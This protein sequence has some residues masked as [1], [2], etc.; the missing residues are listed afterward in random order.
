MKGPIFILVDR[1][2]AETAYEDV[3]I[4]HGTEDYQLRQIMKGPYLSWQTG[5]ELRQ[6]MKGPIFIMVDRTV[7]ELAYEGANIYHG[8]QYYS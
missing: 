6:L 2:R 8:T 1:T 7:V 4:Y 3:H 5:I